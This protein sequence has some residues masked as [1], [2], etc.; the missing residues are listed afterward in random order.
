VLRER[1]VS[2]ISF[3][4]DLTFAAFSLLGSHDQRR[5]AR[6]V[7]RVLL[8]GDRGVGDGVEALEERGEAGFE[9]AVFGDGG[10]VLLGHDFFGFASRRWNVFQSINDRMVLKQKVRSKSLIVTSAFLGY[11]EQRAKLGPYRRS[12]CVY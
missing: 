6:E 4:I 5:I 9:G 2:F 8:V 7:V 12:D 1:I 3:S 10:D 11:F